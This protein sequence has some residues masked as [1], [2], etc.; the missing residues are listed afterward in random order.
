M[1]TKYLEYRKPRTGAGN[2]HCLNPGTG[3]D[4]GNNTQEKPIPRKDP[5]NANPRCG[6]SWVSWEKPRKKNRKNPENPHPGFAFPGSFLGMGFSWVLFPGSVPVP[7]L[8]Q[9]RFPVL[10]LYNQTIE[11]LYFQ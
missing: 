5:G 6:F 1:L 2:L 4:P 3:T 10:F 7:G 8:R 11:Q 9:W